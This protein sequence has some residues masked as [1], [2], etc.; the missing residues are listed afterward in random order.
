MFSSRFFFGRGLGANKCERQREREERET[1]PAQA[2]LSHFPVYKSAEAALLLLY[3]TSHHALGM[4]G[5]CWNWYRSVPNH[6]QQDNS[7]TDS[8]CNESTL[9][10]PPNRSLPQPKYTA[11]IWYCIKA[12]AHITHGSTVT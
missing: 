11:C 4:G 1:E 2:Y 7:T 5:Q 6:K 12:D 10:V 8:E 3:E 9:P